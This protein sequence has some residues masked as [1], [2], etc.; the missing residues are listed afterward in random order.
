MLINTYMSYNDFVGK[1]MRE[2]EVDEISNDFKVA[3]GIMRKEDPETT[4]A[5]LTMLRSA[6]RE[7]TMSA[8]TKELC[9][10]A[11]ALFA[12]CESCIVLH[13]KSALE[14]GATKQELIE[15]CGVALMMGGSPVMPHI[16]IVL[17]TYNRLIPR[18]V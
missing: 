16:S 4:E 9:C 17:K 3:T 14:A 11:V 18:S 2:E 12:R 5:F 13:A 7:G 8:K 15:I 1:S 10:L 6:R